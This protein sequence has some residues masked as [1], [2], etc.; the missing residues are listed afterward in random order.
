[1][2][3]DGIKR[4]LHPDGKG[5]PDEHVTGVWCKFEDVEVLVDGISHRRDTYQRDLETLK[6]ENELVEDHHRAA[7][8]LMAYD[9]KKVLDSVLGS[10]RFSTSESSL[11][12]LHA[13]IE[14][15]GLA[16]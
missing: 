6:I 5:W 14:Q 2:K 15:M 11:D 4:Y 12:R 8:K 7:S 3:S 9:I 1:M 13:F 10:T 16:P